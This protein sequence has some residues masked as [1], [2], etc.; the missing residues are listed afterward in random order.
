MLV[1]VYTR[2]KLPIMS[3]LFLLAFFCAWF[4]SAPALL[5][6]PINDTASP[7]SAS[8]FLH[9]TRIHCS[10]AQFRIGLS[11]FRCENAW[12]KIEQS[13]QPR[14]YAQRDTEHDIFS[15]PFRYLSGAL[16]R[17]DLQ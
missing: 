4:S 16:L 7:I 1:A 15:L 11:K 6:L 2:L 13:I 17:H 8:G 14:L 12:A 3:R 5:A 10:G 9:A